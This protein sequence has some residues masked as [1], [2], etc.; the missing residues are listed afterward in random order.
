MG[1][2]EVAVEKFTHQHLKSVGCVKSAEILSI[3][4]KKIYI[5]QQYADRTTL[6]GAF[7]GRVDLLLQSACFQPASDQADQTGVSYPQARG[8]KRSRLFRTIYIGDLNPMD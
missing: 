2:H 1:R 5:T 3:G 8:L 7:L 6:W 4:R